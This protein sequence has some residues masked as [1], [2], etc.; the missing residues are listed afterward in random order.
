MGFR[1]LL[2]MCISEIKKKKKERI[3]EIVLSVIKQKCYILQRTET[4]V[5]ACQLKLRKVSNHN[6]FSEDIKDCFMNLV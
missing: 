3:R 1:V 6:L 5:T 4:L 2:I